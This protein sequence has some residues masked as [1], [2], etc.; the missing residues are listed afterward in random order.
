[1]KSNPK[2]TPDQILEKLTDPLSIE[3]LVYS[4]FESHDPEEVKKLTEQLYG[5]VSKKN[6]GIKKMLSQN[7]EHLFSCSDLID[8]LKEFSQLAR[9]NQQ[10]LTDLETITSQTNPIS[11]Q[12]NQVLTTQDM[13]FETPK[14]LFYQEVVVGVMNSGLLFQNLV[15]LKCLLVDSTDDEGNDRVQL[16]VDNL[17]KQVI[18]RL[19]E[20]LDGDLE[21]EET[22]QEEGLE[23]IVKIFICLISTIFGLD[24]GQEPIQNVSGM[25]VMIWM[26]EVF[27]SQIEII[28]SK[29]E[30]SQKLDFSEIVTTLLQVLISQVSNIRQVQKVLLLEK[31]I[32]FCN[33]S[34]SKI[35]NKKAAKILT[36]YFNSIFTNKPFKLEENL[37]QDIYSKH[38]EPEDCKK[39]ILM[40][41]YQI[42]LSSEIDFRGIDPSLHQG[43]FQQYKTHVKTI[44]DFEPDLK[45]PK[46]EMGTLE[47]VILKNWQ[48]YVDITVSNCKKTVA[49][50]EEIKTKLETKF[51]EDFNQFIVEYQS[52]ADSIFTDYD[53]LMKQ[54]KE[55]KGMVGK[56]GEIS[57]EE[58]HDF[59]SSLTSKLDK[60]FSESNIK[61]EA[62][63]Q[64]LRSFFF[65]Q[66]FLDRGKFQGMMSKQIQKIQ[67]NILT[68]Y[69]ACQ[70]KES[71][72]EILLSFETYQRTHTIA[73]ER[74][75]IVLRFIQTVSSDGP[76][77]QKFDDLLKYFD[78]KT[79][80]QIEDTQFITL[81]R[82]SCPQLIPYKLTGHLVSKKSEKKGEVIFVEGS[83][84]DLSIL[85]CEYLPK[86][87]F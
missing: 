17:F 31:I 34:I 78:D 10:K 70:P 9:I 18:L 13:L 29:F 3:P 68:A 65:L 76:H 77:Q 84:E 59:I 54:D 85:D 53:I 24:E 19:V 86:I 40:P 62:T 60:F 73:Q 7:H 15:V 79:V 63:T 2:I 37:I 41:C 23:K 75:L 56:K 26:S 81:A 83:G 82:D 44:T 8:Q 66:S 49:F 12:G 6:E 58:N 27:P 74:M 71:T 5:L 51:G 80:S 69:L 43:L 46:V 35:D 47:G 14:S 67:K 16:L 48:I 36:N 39:M 64:N 57:G 32:K 61:A 72:L 38:I 55:L 25:D 50:E 20:V 87:R 4:L 52:R 45:D 22:I 21:P 1:M 28:N 11:N 33:I 42:L 30:N